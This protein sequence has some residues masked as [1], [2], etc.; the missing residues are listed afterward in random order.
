MAELSL[1]CLVYTFTSSY[2]NF[3]TMCVDFVFELCG[4]VYDNTEGKRSRES[5][6]E[7]QGDG[8]YMVGLRHYCF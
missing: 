1:S 8:L 2:L 4:I 6:N 7:K 5:S 3:L